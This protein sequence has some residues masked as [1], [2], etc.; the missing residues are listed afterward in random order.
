MNNWG[1][2]SFVS[3][4]CNRA[5]NRVVSR[6]RI[7]KYRIRLK[8]LSKWWNNLLSDE[9]SMPWW[10]SLW[11]LLWS[12]SASFDDKV[13]EWQFDA[14]LLEFLVEL[15]TELVN[16]VHINIDGQVI[17]WNGVLWFQKALSDDSSSIRYGNIN[18][19]ST[20]WHWNWSWGRSGTSAAQTTKI[21]ACDWAKSSATL[22]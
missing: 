10:V 3:S 5:I 12:Q 16:L 19:S 6:N 15:S 17:M 13:I 14:I 8:S 7:Q 18:V 1:D 11:Y 20:S 21:L 9:A 4:N 2:Q 22:S